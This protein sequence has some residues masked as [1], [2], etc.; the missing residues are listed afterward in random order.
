M[1]LSAINQRRWRNFRANGRGF[2]SLWIFLLLFGLSLGSELI[3]KSFGVRLNNCTFEGLMTVSWCIN[4][5]RARRCTDTPAGAQ[6]RRTSKSS[7]L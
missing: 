2:W 5:S 4:R 1:K 6:R 7:C 3:A